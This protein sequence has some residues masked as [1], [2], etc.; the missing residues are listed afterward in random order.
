MEIELRGFNAL[1]ETTL[2]NGNF[3]AGTSREI[4][5]PY[6]GFAGGQSYPVVI[7]AE[8]FALNI[9]AAAKP[10]SFT[11]SPENDCLYQLLASSEPVS[12]QPIFASLLIQAKT[13]LE[14]THTIR[15]TTDLA[16]KK[17]EI[18]GF[19]GTHYQSLK[20]SDMIKRLMSQYF[21]MHEYV[22][23]H[24]KGE[25]ATAIKTRYHQEILQGVASWLELLQPYLSEQEILNYCVSLYYQ[26]SMITLAG[27]I[28][29]NFKNIAH[30]PGAEIEKVNFP[31]DL[32]LVCA[33]NKRNIKW[34]D[35]TGKKTIVFVSAD[36]PIS[37]VEAIVKARQLSHQQEK[38]TLI[39]APVEKLSS[40]HF[41][42][43]RMIRNG[44]LYFIKDEIWRKEIVAQRVK[45]PF[46]VYVNNGVVRI[47]NTN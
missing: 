27:K 25:P 5:T 1:T 37:M 32:L 39:I 23:Y 42:L 3:Q 29:E 2:F 40:K 12:G 13:L 28:V 34:S 14:S 4:A 24:V 19:I 43:N 18:Q 21:M 7:S 44:N 38:N 9:K 15:T 11:G 35:L 6:Q 22:D 20:H 33:V 41:A 45:L 31:K 36:C 26:R 46:F 10:P 8:D 16:A 30:C 17:K 47:D